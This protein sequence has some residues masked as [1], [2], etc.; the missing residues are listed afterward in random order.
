[1]F[2]VIIGLGDD[3]LDLSLLGRCSLSFCSSLNFQRVHWLCV[4]CFAGVLGWCVHREYL[5]ML[6]AGKDGGRCV[7]GSAGPIGGM[8]R[9][10]GQKVASTGVLLQSCGQP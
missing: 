6:Q 7:V 4:S 3:F 9:G 1:M 5:L 10:G 2:G 8:A